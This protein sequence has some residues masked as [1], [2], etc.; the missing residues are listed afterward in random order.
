[1]STMVSFLELH[2]TD[3]NVSL[4]EAG[5]AVMRWLR[6][7]PLTRLELTD[8]GG[9]CYGTGRRE[10]TDSLIKVRLAGYAAQTRSAPLV[11]ARWARRSRPTR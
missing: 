2:W 1:M 9:M 8:E 10:A 4:H 6:G 3:R 11:R 5:H 7:L